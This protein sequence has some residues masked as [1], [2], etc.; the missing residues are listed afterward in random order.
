MIDGFR[1]RNE[2]SVVVAQLPEL[3]EREKTFLVFCQARARDLERGKSLQPSK[4][5]RR[6]AGGAVL[7]G[8]IVDVSFEQF[9]EFD[10]GVSAERLK[11]IEAES[12]E[13]PRIAMKF[14]F[15]LDEAVR[16]YTS[17]IR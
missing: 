2:A 17:F 12:N 10:C 15:E 4:A 14:R 13:F 5:S 3:R 8:Q 7:P 16:Q 11:Y 9:K 1:D 6:V